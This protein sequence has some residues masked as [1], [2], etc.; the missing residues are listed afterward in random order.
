MGIK[1]IFTTN[2]NLGAI[3]QEATG[4]APQVSSATHTAVL[5][6]DEKGG[7]AAAATGFGLVAL[8]YDEAD[9]IL[10]ID[11]PF[12]AILWDNNLHLPLFMAR[13]EDPSQ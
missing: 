10:R 2:S 5:S 1:E 13:I 6:I 4:Y 12:L 7:S 11:T 3:G 9:V 8:S